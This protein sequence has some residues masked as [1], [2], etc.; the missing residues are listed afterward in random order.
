MVANYTSGLIK[1]MLP[2]VWEQDD[3]AQKQNDN[4]YGLYS[5]MVYWI[6]FHKKSYKYVIHLNVHLYCDLNDHK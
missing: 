6:R 1:R 3:D 2:S 4:S 5:N